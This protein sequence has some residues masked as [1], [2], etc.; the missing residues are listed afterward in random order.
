[1]KSK[2]LS[3]LKEAGVTAEECEKLFPILFER[4]PIGIYI[5]QDGRFEFCNPRFLQFTGYTLDEL[6]RK[7][8]LELVLAE[9]RDRVRENAIKMLKGET[10]FFFP[11]EFRVVN[12]NGEVLWIMETVNSIPYRRKRATLGNFMNIT[13]LKEMEKALRESEKR[14]MKLSITDHLTKLYNSRYFY[15]QLESEIKR[16]L[17]YNHPLSLILLDIDNFKRYND[18]YGHLEGDAVLARFGKIIREKV[19]ETDSAYRYG[20][21]EF[22][23][24]LPETPGEVAFKAA[25][26][27][28]EGLEAETFFPAPE[29]KEKVTVSGG[30]AQYRSGETSKEFILRA[31]KS[32]YLAKKRGKNQIFFLY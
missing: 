6:I 1:M 12:K 9:D 27:I 17:R 18:T 22:T 2:F 20:G 4:S 3:L 7:N 15:K 5:V 32:M 21:E 24:T 26:R 13:A 23:V 25:E 14:F 10:S 30:V 31:D 8:P 11:Y 16:T 28:R 19:R 29:K